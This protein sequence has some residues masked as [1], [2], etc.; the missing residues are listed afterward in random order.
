MNNDKAAAQIKPC[1][2]TFLKAQEEYYDTGAVTTARC[3]RCGDVLRLT[4]QGDSA[5][6][7]TC[8][9]ELYNG[10]LRGL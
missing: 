5:L 7:M 6:M 1:L 2:E 3:E 9:C 8:T 10:A 4:P